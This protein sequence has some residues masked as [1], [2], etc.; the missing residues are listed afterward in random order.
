MYTVG[1][2]ELFTKG[3]E[4]ITLYL[5]H[6][7]KVLSLYIKLLISS[8]CKRNSASNVNMFSHK[9][10]NKAWFKDTA[11]LHRRKKTNEKIY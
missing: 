5:E 1:T 10:N 2:E 7:I 8:Y 9:H 11:M 4:L 6:A 3:N